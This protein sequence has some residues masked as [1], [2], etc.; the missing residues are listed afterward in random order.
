MSQP[1]RRQWRVPAVEC[2]ARSY[3][4]GRTRSSD[5]HARLPCGTIWRALCTDAV[6]IDTFPVVVSCATLLSFILTSYTNDPVSAEFAAAAAA[7]AISKTVAWTMSSRPTRM[8]T[9][10]GG[11]VLRHCQLPP[12]P[13]HV[14]DAPWRCRRMR[15]SHILMTSRVRASPLLAPPATAL[16]IRDL[17]VMRCGFSRCLTSVGITPCAVRSCRRTKNGIKLRR[18]TVAIDN[19]SNTLGILNSLA[20]SAVCFT[21]RFRL[22]YPNVILWHSKTDTCSA[23]E[24][25]E[26]TESCLCEFIKFYFAIFLFVKRLRVFFFTFANEN[27]WLYQ[28]MYQ[29]QLCIAKTN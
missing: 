27:R 1:G 14:R 15:Y 13:P 9:T 19:Q 3:D 24:H 20:R 26:F 11:F 2:K 4:P 25:Y 12:P 16:S 10:A 22:S 6:L 18:S 17:A 21:N 23:M 7:G 8:L 29:M 28:T 5:W